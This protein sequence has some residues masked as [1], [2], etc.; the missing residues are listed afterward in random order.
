MDGGP[1]IR[2]MYNINKNPR[3]IRKKNWEIMVLRKS[4]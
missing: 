3:T 4:E 2:S 1:T